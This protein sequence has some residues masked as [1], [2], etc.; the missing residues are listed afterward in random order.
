MVRRFDPGRPIPATLVAE[1]LE[2]AARAP[3]AGFSQGW[4][5]LVL[6]E[7]AGRDRFWAAATPADAAAAPDGWLA[8]VSAA[9]TLILCLAD[10]GAY[11]RRYA[12]SDKSG[13]PPA[14]QPWPI[15]YWHTDTAMGALLILLGATDAGVGSLFFGVPARHHEQVRASFGIPDDRAIVGAI[16]LGHESDR[17]VSPSLRRGRRGGEQISHWGRFGVPRR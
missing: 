4:D 7:P 8:G 2:L 5:Y 3:S 11:R 13:L 17:V 6:Q 16:A 9:P 10:E 14:E 1:L 12:A 15:P